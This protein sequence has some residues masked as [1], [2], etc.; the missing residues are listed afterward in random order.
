MSIFKYDQ[1]RH[2]KQDREEAWEE[3][4]K[5]GKKAGIYSEICKDVIRPSAQ[6]CARNPRAKCTKMRWAII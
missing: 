6:E 5:E 4:R 3:G 1:E 2:I